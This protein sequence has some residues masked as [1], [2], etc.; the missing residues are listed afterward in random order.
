M[1][2]AIYTL[3]TDFSANGK[4]GQLGKSGRLGMGPRNFDLKIAI[5]GV[6]GK[7][8][9]KWPIGGQ[10]Q[11]D[12]DLKLPL[13]RAGEEWAHLE[14]GGKFRWGKMD[15]ERGDAG[16]LQRCSPKGDCGED[17]GYFMCYLAY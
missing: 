10:P 16:Q 13:W 8:V 12:R 2:I 7:W 4:C 3:F 5:M 1:Y 11:G 14:M 6:G 15:G 9:G 17:W